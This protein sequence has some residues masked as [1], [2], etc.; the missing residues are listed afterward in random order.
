ML[1]Q[2]I[3]KFIIN[4]TSINILPSKFRTKLLKCLKNIKD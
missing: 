2:K 1:K 4:A 3:L